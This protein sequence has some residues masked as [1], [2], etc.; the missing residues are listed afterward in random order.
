M[1]PIVLADI[2]WLRHVLATVSQEV[3]VRGTG[4]GGARNDFGELGRPTDV[5]HAMPNKIS[6]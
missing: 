3:V 6:E 5:V 1:L 4:A 2:A